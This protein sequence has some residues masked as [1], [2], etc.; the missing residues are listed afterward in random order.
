MNFV[1][2][3]LPHGT[4]EEDIRE[5]LGDY[6][7]PTHISFLKNGEHQHSPY[8]CLVKLDIKDPITGSIL[9]DHLNNMCWKGCHI[10]FHRLIF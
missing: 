5:F 1:I 10:S 3:N 9:A 4:N 2:G 8:E 6:H 7:H